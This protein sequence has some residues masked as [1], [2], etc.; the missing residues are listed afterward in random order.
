MV[1]IMQVVTL[2][3]TLVYVQIDYVYDSDL[4]RGHLLT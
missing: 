4:N 1:I 2:E 3:T